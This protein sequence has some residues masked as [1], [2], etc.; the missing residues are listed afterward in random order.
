MCNLLRG[1]RPKY[2][3]VKEGKL[4]RCKDAPNN[5]SSQAPADDKIHYIAPLHYD[6]SKSPSDIVRQLVLLIDDKHKL[7][8]MLWVIALSV[9]FFGA[10]FIPEYE[11]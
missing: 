1:K 3:G 6:S 4:A 2:L 9:G 11:P 5:V 8:M 7:I 10:K